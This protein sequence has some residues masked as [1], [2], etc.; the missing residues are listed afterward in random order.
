MAEITPQMVKELREMTGAGMGD[1]K[2]ALVEAEGNTKEAI[3][4][5]RKKGAASASNRA[6]RVANE[7]LIFTKTSPDLKKAVIIEINCETDFVSRNEEFIKYVSLLR[8]AY[9]ENDVNSL[10]ELLKLKIGSD[11]I[12]SLHNEILAKF[13]EKIQIR[14]LEKLTV[15]NG[16]ID[17]YMHT[18]NKL[19]VL[20]VF[21]GASNPTPAAKSL[22]HDIT[23]QI[24]AMNPKF[25]DRS[26]IDQSTLENEKKLYTQQAI[27]EGKKPEIAEK[28]AQGKLEKYFSEFCL[29]EQAFVKDSSKVVGD[30]LKEISNEM[31]VEIK[32]TSFRRYFLGESEDK[33]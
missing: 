7:G 29:L 14:R 8:D 13:G 33:L 27:D 15:E 2:K 9:F 16:W 23:M 1:C 24:A 21:E 32:I 30:I 10:D 5:L 18:G 4:I 26:Q 25:I 11:T 3:E 22:A 31:G 20:A 6:G 17:E 12:E 19:A 28:I